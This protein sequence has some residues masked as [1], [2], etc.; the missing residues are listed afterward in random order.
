MSR[1]K[2]VIT[3]RVACDGLLEQLAE[4]HDDRSM[5][6]AESGAR[7][8]CSVAAGSDVIGH[9]LLLLTSVG[10]DDLSQSDLSQSSNE[11]LLH[12]MVE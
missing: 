2:Q 7:G 6:T 12:A 3:G 10:V 8:R 4:Q 11:Q 9:L 5:E 1:L